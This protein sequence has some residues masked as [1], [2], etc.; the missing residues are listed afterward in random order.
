MQMTVPLVD[1]QGNG[2]NLVNEGVQRVDDVMD[3]EANEMED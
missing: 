3:V 1:S 2:G